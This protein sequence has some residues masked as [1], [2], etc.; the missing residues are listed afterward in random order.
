MKQVILKVR[1]GDKIYVPTSWYIDR[2]EDDFEGGIATVKR[3]FKMMSFNWT[4]IIGPD[5]EKLKQKYK[6]QIAHPSPDYTKH[7]PFP[8]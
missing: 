8:V 7:E 4:Q 2:G 6:G 3:V 5:Q 1:V